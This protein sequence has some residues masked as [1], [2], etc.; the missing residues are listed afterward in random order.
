M[1]SYKLNPNVV[2]AFNEDDD[3]LENRIK[4]LKIDSVT[5]LKHETIIYDKNTQMERYKSNFNQDAKL[6]VE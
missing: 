3:L 2:F 6:V 1:F 4:N 5:G